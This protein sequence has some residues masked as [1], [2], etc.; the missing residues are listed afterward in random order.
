MSTLTPFMCAQHLCTVPMVARKR[1]WVPWKLRGCWELPLQELQ[2]LLM[3]T[4]LPS[5]GFIGISQRSGCVLSVRVFTLSI[6][7]NTQGCQDSQSV[8]RPHFFLEV[9]VTLTS[10][11]LD[12]LLVVCFCFFL[13]CKFEWNSIKHQLFCT[14]FEKNT[15]NAN[16]VPLS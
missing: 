7:N 12:L 5:P 8:P 10:K 15:A 14:W 11:Q 9:T 1:C 13:L 4:H 2:K 3:A 16:L 6:C